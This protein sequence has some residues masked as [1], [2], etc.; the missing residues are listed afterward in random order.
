[1]QIFTNAIFFFQ[2]FELDVDITPSTIRAAVKREDHGVALFM[3]LRLNEGDLTREV[4]EQ[5]PH[6]DID[7]LA[8]DMPEK[9]VRR[10]LKWIGVELETSRHL[11]F[12]ALW[13]HSIVRHHSLWIRQRSA[14]LMPVLN[15]LHKNLLV[16]S[17]DMT[18]IC[19]QNLH[20]MKFL[21]TMSELKKAAAIAK[22]EEGEDD[23]S[24]DDDDKEDESEEGEDSDE[25]EM[26][27]NWESH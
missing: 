7:L 5:V 6:G 9:Y 26:E 13:C 17:T 23:I 16:K 25:M 14:D 20:T 2:P 18:R 11:H 8:T 19:E 21:L 4:V 3:A 10:L 27:Q 1:M 12:Y 22:E 24:G 15:L